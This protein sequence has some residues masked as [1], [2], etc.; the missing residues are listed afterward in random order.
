[1]ASTVV[2]GFALVPAIHAA[3]QTTAPNLFDQRP[4]HAHGLEGHHQAEDRPRGSDARFIV[5][6]IG[7]SPLFTVGS[8]RRGVGAQPGFSRLFKPGEHGILLVYLNA[9]GTL[10]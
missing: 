1:M 7:T 4:R 9:R 10:P 3:R 2:V 8:T 5:R 6:N